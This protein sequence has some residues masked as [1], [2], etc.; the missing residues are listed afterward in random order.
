M[1]FIMAKEINTYRD[2]SI[3]WDKKAERFQLDARALGAE[4]MRFATKNEAVQMAKELFDKWSVGVP[5]VAEQRWSVDQ[6]ITLYQEVGKIRCEDKEDTYGSSYY[7]TQIQQ[8]GVIS[9]E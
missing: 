5:V 6:A 2:L 3:K 9:M 7:A 8:F 4:R 1:E